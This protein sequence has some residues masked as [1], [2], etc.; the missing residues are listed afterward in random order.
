MFKYDQNEGFQ[1]LL[2]LLVNSLAGQG[3]YNHIFASEIIRNV[4][5]KAI[6]VVLRSNGGVQQV[7]R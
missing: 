6:P 3:H 5:I 4:K 1:K 7:L 2:G